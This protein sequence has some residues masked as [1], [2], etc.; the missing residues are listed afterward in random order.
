[1]VIIFLGKTPLLLLPA[2]SLPLCNF[3]ARPERHHCRR[4]SHFLVYSGIST[5]GLL[6]MRNSTLRLGET[7]RPGEGFV[8]SAEG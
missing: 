6:L 2:S 1:M 7:G 3:L 5:R 4:V 8:I